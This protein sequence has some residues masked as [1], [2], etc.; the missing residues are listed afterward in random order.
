MHQAHYEVRRAGS[1]KVEFKTGGTLTREF[2]QACDHAQQ[3]S[4]DS[5]YPG[6][7]YEVRFCGH[8]T[9]DGLVAAYVDGE[10]VEV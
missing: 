6:H 8:V 5:D 7:R 3:L 1:S 10:K 9:T 4:K 2:D